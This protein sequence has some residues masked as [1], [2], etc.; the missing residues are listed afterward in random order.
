[1]WRTLKVE[2]H[3]VLPAPR[4]PLSHNDGRHDLLA[5]LRLTLLDGSHDEV[6]HTSSG[7][8]V[9]AALVSLNG[10]DVEVLGTRVVAAVHHGAHR[11]TKS[12]TE[13]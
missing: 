7:K 5:E 1:M 9:Q 6:A 13:L 12:H 11:Q 10:D 3:A 4:L 8:A 2:V